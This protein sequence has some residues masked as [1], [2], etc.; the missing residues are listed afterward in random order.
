MIIEQQCGQRKGP[1][2]RKQWDP[3]KQRYSSN[4]VLD[5]VLDAD[6]CFILLDLRLPIKHVL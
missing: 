1:Y 4:I 5:D 2:P 3:F 6:G